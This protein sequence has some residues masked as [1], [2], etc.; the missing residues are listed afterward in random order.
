MSQHILVVDDSQT[1]RDMLVF[2]LK[3]SGYDVDEASD[4]QTGLETARTGNYN[5]V[6]TDLN[7]PNMGGFELIEA[8]R[9]EPKYKSIPIM[10]LTTESDD[11]L[12]DKGKKLGA[13]GWIVKPFHPD[14]LIQLANRLCPV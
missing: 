4:G 6:I 1:M 11:S 5:M 12:K 14:K 13:T 10:M 9:R 3:N 7:M 8:L 2:T